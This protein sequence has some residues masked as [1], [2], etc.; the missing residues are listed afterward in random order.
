MSAKL[1]GLED[2]EDGIVDASTTVE[3]DPDGDFLFLVLPEYLSSLNAESIG[4][5]FPW[6]EE[7]AEEG[8][9]YVSLEISAEVLLRS[10]VAV[11]LSIV[12]SLRAA[13]FVGPRDWFPSVRWAALKGACVSS[14]SAIIFF[15]LFDDWGSRSSV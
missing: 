10:K 8:I 15:H 11:L 2:I 5:R 9:E 3:I 4:W 14:C 7:R 13:L 12:F 1:K 6:C